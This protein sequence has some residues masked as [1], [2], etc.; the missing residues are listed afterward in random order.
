MVLAIALL[1][2]SPC[3]SA[4]AIYG[5]VT[6]PAGGAANVTVA[7]EGAGRRLELAARRDGSFTFPGLP[8][9]QYRVSARKGA[10]AAFETVRLAA[11]SCAEVALRMQADRRIR[12]RV[13]D[14][15][16]KPAGGIAV[17]LLDAS[18]ILRTPSRIITPLRSPITGT[19]GE[20]RFEF[21]GLQPG[22]YYLGINL[23]RPIST[24]VPYSRVYYPGTEDLEFAETIRISEEA[25]VIEADLPLPPAQRERAVTG[26]VVWPD[27]RPAAGALIYLEDPYFPTRTLV[28]QA[29]ADPQGLFSVMCFD[30]TRYVLHAVSACKE[31]AECRSAAPYE[32]APGVEP[33]LRLVLAIPGHSALEAY[34]KTLQ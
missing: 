5:R 18:K 15:D 7:L 14:A 17:T 22:D 9:G 8:A 13:I 33:S 21:R 3:L 11:G 27:G 2:A 34:K 1:A 24:A 10:Y 23:D 25:G 28:P 4:N 26:V 6:A 30:R 20:G 12:G 16:G 29:T 31:L 19:D 32:I